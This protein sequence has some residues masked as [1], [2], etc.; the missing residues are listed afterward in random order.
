VARSCRRQIDWQE[1]AVVEGAIHPVFCSLLQQMMRVPNGAGIA[2]KRVMS[3]LVDP[4]EVIRQVSP[5]S[6]RASFRPRLP[7]LVDPY[8]ARVAETLDDEIDDWEMPVAE[9]CHI[10]VEQSPRGVRV[11]SWRRARCWGAEEPTR[12]GGRQ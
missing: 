3:T 7:T 4:F 11:E 10:V 2:T 9:P 12:R 5:L 1:S 6:T 8:E